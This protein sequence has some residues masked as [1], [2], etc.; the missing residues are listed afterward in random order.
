MANEISSLS[1]TDASNTARFPESQAPSTVNDGARA[2]EGMLARGLKDTIDGALTTG[3]T[4]TA[5]T[6]TLNRSSV[7]AWYTGLSFRVKWNATCGATPTINPTGSAALG[8]K[9]L[10]WPN[11]TQVTSNQLVSGGVSDLY[12]DGTNVQVIS[13]T[14]ALPVP[15]AMGGTN[16]TTASAARTALGLGT[17]AVENTSAV[18]AMTYAGTQNFADNILQRPEI[19]DYGETV[20]ALGSIGGGTQDIDL[21]LGNVVTGTV[22]T[23][24]TTFTF[25]NPSATGKGCSFSLR[26]T[27]GGSQTVN[28]PASVRW[29][30]GTAPTLTTSGDDWLTFVTTDAG[31]T[32]DGF[33]SGQAMA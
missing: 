4:S 23:S 9:S 21:T 27:N 30:S 15:V 22:D 19:K 24:T 16:S 29:P 33:V 25:S 31:T 17:M 6:C 8:A 10:Y 12:Y 7:S 5:Y 14:S 20:N 26:L 1:T 3:G 32:W 28:W 2:L 18:P 11:G 13:Y